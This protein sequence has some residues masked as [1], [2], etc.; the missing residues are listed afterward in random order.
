MSTRQSVR[1]PRPRILLAAISLFLFV[2]L[3]PAGSDAAQ[4]SS[5]LPPTVQALHP[6]GMVVV[7][8]F[9]RDATKTRPIGGAVVFDTNELLQLFAPLRVVRYEDADAV[10][11]FGQFET[12]VVRL[13][14]V[15]P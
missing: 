11:D 1:S 10:A 8:G 14:A 13:A 7:E 4:Q 9:H 3:S 15:K 12:R 6:G 2:G 5:A